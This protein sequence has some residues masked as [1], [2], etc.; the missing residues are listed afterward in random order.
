VE[1]RPL[2]EPRARLSSDNVLTQLG[3][4]LHEEMSLAPTMTM[5]R[6][7]AVNETVACAFTHIPTRRRSCNLQVAPDTGRYRL[8]EERQE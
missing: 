6:Y 1:Q 5:S 2:A 3:G 7:R 4:A 8:L